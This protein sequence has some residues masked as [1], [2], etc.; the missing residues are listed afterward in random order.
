MADAVE[1]VTDAL[2]KQPDQGL[3]QTAKDLFGGAVGGVAQVLS[4]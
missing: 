2:V 1:D 3:K 4:G